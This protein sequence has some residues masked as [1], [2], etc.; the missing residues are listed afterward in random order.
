M[1]LS[2]SRAI[3]ITH[4]PWPLKIFLAADIPVNTVFHVANK[5]FPACARVARLKTCN[6]VVFSGGMM[7]STLSLFPPIIC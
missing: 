7:K 5:S 4:L 2:W 6:L 1:A 3:L